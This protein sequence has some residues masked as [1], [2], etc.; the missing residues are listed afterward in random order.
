MLINEGNV[1][2]HYWFSA[3]VNDPENYSPYQGP[4]VRKVYIKH[5]LD[6]CWSHQLHHLILGGTIRVRLNSLA[7]G[8]LN[9]HIV[10]NFLMA[11]Q[12]VSLPL[13][14][15]SAALGSMGWQNRTVHCVAYK[16]RLQ[17][18]WRKALSWETFSWIGDDW[19][20]WLS[21]ILQGGRIIL[22]QVILIV[23]F[24]SVVLD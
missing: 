24:L 10:L 6:C 8:F 11:S 5:V 21:S 15:L 9:K 4:T 16:R 18:P 13:P 23:T 14:T 12:D 22:L 1:R 3:Q 2:L 20:S 7:P 17:A 19:S